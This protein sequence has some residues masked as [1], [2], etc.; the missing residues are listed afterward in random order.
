MAVQVESQHSKGTEGGTEAGL[1]DWRSFIS[2]DPEF[3]WRV[4]HGG[5]RAGAEMSRPIR[6]L[7]AYMEE[8]KRLLIFSK[9]V[10]VIASFPSRSSGSH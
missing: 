8:G 7:L 2:S 10:Q 3:Q 9:E 4:F 6:G 1:E 5:K